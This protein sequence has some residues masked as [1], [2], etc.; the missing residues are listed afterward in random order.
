MATLDILIAIP[1]IP[2]VPLFLTWWLPW[3]RWIPWRKLPKLMLGPYVL[4]AGFA[5]WH[6]HFD[7]WFVLIVIGVGVILMIIGAV[8]KAP[9]ALPST[10]DKKFLNSLEDWLRSQSEIMILIRDS[11]AAG[12]KSFEFFTSFATLRERLVRLKAETSVTAFRKPQLALRGRVDDEFIGRSLSSIPAG[13]EFLV[14]ETDPRMATQQWLFHH[15]AGESQDELQQVL[16]GLRGRLVAVGEYPQ[17]L[18][19]DPDVISA[20]VP[21]RDGTVKAG[22]Y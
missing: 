21:N 5:A 2:L 18:E 9:A 16:E 3:E 8:E 17:W 19:D 1:V 15:D 7:H 14:L 4:Y 20:Y 22:V 10:T 13:S 12:S 11:R 6:F